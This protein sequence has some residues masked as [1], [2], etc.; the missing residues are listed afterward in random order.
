[1]RCLDWTEG[2]DGHTLGLS[3]IV[4]LGALAPWDPG[5]GQLTRRMNMHGWM[6]A[7]AAMLVA[8]GMTVGCGWSPFE[9]TEAKEKPRP[10]PA[11][12]VEVAPVLRGP[13]EA[14]IESRA[15]L[16]AEAEVRVFARTSNR[17]TAL[18]VEEGDEVQKDQLLVRLEDDIQRTQLGKAEARV[19]RARQE[20]ARQQSLYDQSLIS[21]QAYRD[22]QFELRQ[23]EL[24]LDDA[25]R[26]LAFTEVR[27]PIAGTVSRRLVRY[28]DLVNVNQHMFDIVDFNSIVARVHVPERELAQ[29]ALGQP[30]RVRAQMLGDRVVDGEVRLISPVIDARTGLV[31]VTVGFEDVGMLRPGMYV[32]VEIVTATRPDAL[33]L[34]KRSVVIDGDQYF[35]YRLGADRKVERLLLR[36]RLTDRDHIEPFAGFEAGDLIVIAGQT[37]LKDG[38]RVRLA[39]DPEPSM[40]TAR[41][42]GDPELSAAQ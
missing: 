23:L 36:P 24:A 41:K 5:A 33:L 7:S 18:L 2:Q 11:V 27:A 21:E 1:M 37:G 9:R 20:F 28:G 29:L 38:A 35:V 16:E 12:P 25:L 26:E 22:A 15:H 3:W 34:S 39:N 10:E 30:A 6:A 4:V 13:I 8:M 19:E 32:D 17:V 42:T 31:K 14:T 40:E